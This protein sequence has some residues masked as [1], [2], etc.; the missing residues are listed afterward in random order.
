[1]NA[2]SAQVNVTIDID[3]K[4]TLLLDMY[5]K[6]G[7]EYR[8]IFTKPSQNLCDFL[9]SDIIFYDEIQKKSNLPSKNTCPIPRVNFV[10]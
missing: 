9:N 6:Q 1:M 5:S 3:N 4:W 7:N 2:I 10:D 8:K